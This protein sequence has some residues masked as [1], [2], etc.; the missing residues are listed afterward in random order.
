MSKKIS[1]ELTVK[2]WGDIAD[3]LSLSAELAHQDSKSGWVTEEEAADLVKVCDESEALA[4]LIQ[5]AL[6]P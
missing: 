3:A 1:I 5:E 4:R 2:Q 6:R